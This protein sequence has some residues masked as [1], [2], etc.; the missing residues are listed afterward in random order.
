M[1][2]LNGKK[3]LFR[4]VSPRSEPARVFLLLALLLGLLFVMRGFSQGSVKPL[5]LA[6]PTPTRT[7]DSYAIEGETH[8]AAGNLDKAIIS[9]QLATQVNPNEPRLWIELARIQT[10]STRSITGDDERAARLAEALASITKAVEIAPDDSNAHAV[11]G[12]V[13]DWNADPVIAKD[14]VEALLTEA[15]QEVVQALQ[16]DN[17][18]PLALAY[19]AEILLD[20]QKLLQSEQYIL[21]ALEKGSDLLDVHRVNALVQETLGNYSGAISEYQKAIEIAP[22]LTFLYLQIG[23]NYRYIE[24][25]ERSL[26]YFS[27]AVAINSQLGIQDPLPYIAIAK[28]YVQ[29]GEFFSASRNIRKALVFNPYSADVYGQAGIIFFQARNYEGAIPALKCAVRGCTAQESCDVRQCDEASDPQ[30]AIE[31]LPL[32]DNTVGYYYIYGSVL[33]G[34]QQTGNRNCDEA[35]KVLREV[36]AVYSDEPA[37]MTPVNSSQEICRANG[38]TP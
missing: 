34:M 27:R 13:L 28:T 16:I 8:F 4:R 33:A 24:D 1:I 38:W 7:V 29:Q 31:G 26:E 14:K 30:I 9:Y 11:R 36:A 10:Y 5:F 22:N 2:D 12:F 23:I 3:P 19:Y 25:Y 32:T 18:N 15:E 35:V 20:Q 21:Q 37:I 17:A 6:T